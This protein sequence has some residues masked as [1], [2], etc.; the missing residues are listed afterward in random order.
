MSAFIESKKPLLFLTFVKINIT[1]PT[2]KFKK[3]RIFRCV[4]FFIFL[5]VV[6]KLVHLSFK[7]IKK[8]ISI[9]LQLWNYACLSNVCPKNEYMCINM[10]VEGCI[11]TKK[12]ENLY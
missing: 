7:T 8:C 10:S 5:M 11:P 4:T 1:R 12:S 6:K 2:P 9:Y 3:K